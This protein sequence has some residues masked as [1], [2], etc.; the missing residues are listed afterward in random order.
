MEKTA[1]VV[2]VSGIVGR[3]L[4]DLLVAE[5]GWTVYGIARQPGQREGIIPVAVDLQ[6]AVSVKDA[7]ESVKPTHI[8]LHTWLRQPTEA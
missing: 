1:L 7:L 8:F 5:Q 4:A 3:N 6:D 2:G